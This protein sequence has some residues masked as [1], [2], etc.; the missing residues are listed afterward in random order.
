ME[1]RAATADDA[2]VAARMLHDFN[3]E[4]EDV[5]PPPETIARRLIRLLED[6]DTILLLG[7]D[8]PDGLALL[9][10]RTSLWTDGLECYLA[11]LYVVPHLRGRGL[12]RELMG[13]AREIR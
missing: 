12:G 10:F 5:T 7:G 9:R 4:Y 1:V 13:A 6:G 2:P 3:A 8:G 11:E